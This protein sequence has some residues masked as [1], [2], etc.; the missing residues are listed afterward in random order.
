M[1]EICE[2]YDR[3]CIDCGE[4][5]T[6]DLDGTQ[7][8]VSCGRCIDTPDTFRSLNVTDFVKNQGKKK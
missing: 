6:C 7:R 2:L 5:D 1:S 4:C 8:C 3:T